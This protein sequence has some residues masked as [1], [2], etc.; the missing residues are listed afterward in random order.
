[1]LSHEE[2]MRL[3]A[4]AQQGDD[5]AKQTLVV[6]NTPLLKSIIKRYIG[7]H[8]EYDDLFQISSIGL[9]KAI[10]NFSTE[11]N[12]RFSTYAVPMI[13]GEVKR[14]MRDDGYIKVSRSLKTQA[15]KIAQYIDNCR[16]EGQE[17]TVE[18]VAQQFEMEVSDVV[19]AMDSAKMPVSLYDSAND[20][21]G[22]ALQLVD[23]LSDNSDKKLVDNVILKDMLSQLS[24]REKKIVFLRY[25]RDMTQG[26]IAAQLGVSQVQV[27][28]LEN[29]IIE[30]LKKQY[31]E[32]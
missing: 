20:K 22:K 18:E 16:K 9:L 7:K 1:M 15:N 14:Y 19:F 8:I 17:P 21:D 29:K 5:E 26:E 11:Y 6:E 3:I 23:R 12:V 25:Y 10:A 30:K 28:R 24:D 27:S 31:D 4:L 32:Q 2:T 13:L